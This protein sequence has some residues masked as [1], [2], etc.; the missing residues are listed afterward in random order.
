MSRLLS[1]PGLY[2]A[3]AIVVGVICGWV[4]H[5]LWRGLLPRTRS[6]EFWAGIPVSARGM[7]TSEEAPE[8]LRHYRA[9]IGAV[10]RYAGR[11]TF[12]ILVAVTPIVAITFLLA[13]IDPSNRLAKSIEVHPANAAAPSLGASG[14]R[15]M[16]DE[17]LIIDRSALGDSV[18]R[19]GGRTLDADEL[20][21]KQALCSGTFSCLSLEMMLFQTHRIDPGAVRGPVVVRPVLLD[22]NPFWPYFNDLDF[23]FLIALTAGGTAAAWWSRRRRT[24]P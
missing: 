6:R 5:H 24:H 19:V 20:A 18:V 12:A 8:M 11:N 9:L 13:A 14:N 4:F 15:R 7:L 23:S 21:R 1:A 17:G 10:F 2:V 22:A 3:A 16:D